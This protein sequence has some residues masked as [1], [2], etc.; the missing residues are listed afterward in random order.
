MSSANYEFDIKY[1]ILNS[2]TPRHS[3]I[4]ARYKQSFAYFVLRYRLPHNLAEIILTL[5]E[6][7]DILVSQYGEVRKAIFDRTQ[8]SRGD[9]GKVIYRISQLKYRLQHDGP[10]HQFSGAEPDKD[11]W[12]NFLLN[13]EDGQNTFFSTC[14]LYAECYVFR[15]LICY[16]E[17]TQTL[18][19]FDYYVM[20]KHKSLIA[21]LSTIEI[22]LFGIRTVQSSDDVLRFLLRLNLWG[23][24]CDISADT[25]KYNVKR[26]GPFE[27]L[28]A[29]EKNII[30]D[31]TTSVINSFKLADHTKP[32]Q[33]DFICDNAGYEL[34]V[35]FIL[36]H[37]L[38]E[39]KLV[40]K[41]RFHMKAVPWFVTDAT[42]TD[43]HWTLQQLKKQAGRCTQEYARI[44]LQNLNEGKFEV[45][46]ADYFWTSPYEF[47]RMRDVRPDLY[48]Q[49]TQAHMII[50]KGDCNYRK[51]IGDF[52]W[53][54]SEP[55]ITCLRGFQPA[56]ICSLRIV[57]TEIICGMSPGKNEDLVKKNKDWMI[58]GEYGTIQFIEKNYCGCPITTPNS[59]E[60][61]I[62][63]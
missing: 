6:N 63:N 28:R 59:I 43:F 33:V 56:N 54:A 61:S 57:K 40:D 37:Y 13:L 51:L 18:K 2:R 52:R 8:E 41:V 20:K 62:M 21:F 49:L 32:V 12:N 45:A 9:F 30:I 27:H 26:K 31:S 44:W 7:L 46:E 53:D 38:L 24:Q 11:F 4:S 50:I 42:I 25:E 3:L 34:V 36:A 47:Y 19:T 35:D 5:S 55:F 17:N 58:S 16:L 10:F 1:G 22:I 23:N 48:E 39:S 29:Y 14:F 60:H 15:R